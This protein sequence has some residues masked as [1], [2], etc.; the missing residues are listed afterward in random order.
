MISGRISVSQIDE[1]AAQVADGRH[2]EEKAKLARTAPAVGNID[3]V[4]GTPCV[5][6]QLLG[7]VPEAGPTRD[8]SYF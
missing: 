2:I 1:P 4:R 3:Y 7:N 8:A 5:S 6:G